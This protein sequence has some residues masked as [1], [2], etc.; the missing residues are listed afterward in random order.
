VIGGFG[1]DSRGI[2]VAS[3]STRGATVPTGTVHDQD[4]GGG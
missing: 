4:C 3:Y 1:A 2:M